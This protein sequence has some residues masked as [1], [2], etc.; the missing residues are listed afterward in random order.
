[1]KLLLR[2]SQ[3]QGMLG[4]VVFS[5]E[6]RAELTPAERANITR[7]KFGGAILYERKPMKESATDTVKIREFPH[8]YSQPPANFG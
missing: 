8:F 2:R 4:K 3:R 7:Y 6:V 1:M 5:L